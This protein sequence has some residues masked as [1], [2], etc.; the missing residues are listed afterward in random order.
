M[1][2]TNTR[3]H[4]NH[5]KGG[6]VKS[7]VSLRPETRKCAIIL[8]ETVSDGLDIGIDKLFAVLPVCSK[9]KLAIEWLISDHPNA[10]EYAEAVLLELENLEI[11]ALYEEAKLE[12]M[13]PY[14]KS[15]AW[16]I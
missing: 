2:G 5:N 15:S 11:E 10:K 1:R 4:G 7:S 16:I 13:L 8:G 9:A 14:Q 6:K 12:G 3:S